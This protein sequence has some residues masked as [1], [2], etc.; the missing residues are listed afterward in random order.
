MKLA[1][2]KLKMGGKEAAKLCME[3]QIL[4]GLLQGAEHVPR[5]LLTCEHGRRRGGLRQRLSGE[6]RVTNLIGHH[7]E[8]VLDLPTVR[9]L[10]SA[11][12]EQ[13][14]SPLVDASLVEDPAQRIGDVG[15]LRGS[16]FRRLGEL[17]RSFL[18]AAVFRIEQGE[19]I[20]RHGEA[21][22]LSEDL[23]V[24]LLSLPDVAFALVESR[25][26]DESRRVLRVDLEQFVKLG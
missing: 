2:K 17:E 8:V 22:L 14:E 18:V 3:S 16:L 9:Q 26:E 21:R 20:S 19:V 1:S 11:L 15:I 6:I 5:F 4:A 12:L 10:G 23:L 13:A 24:D 25:R 7:T